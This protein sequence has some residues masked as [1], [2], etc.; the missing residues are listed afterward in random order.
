MTDGRIFRNEKRVRVVRAVKRVYPICILICI[1]I[2]CGFIAR[3][4][5]D[6]E[7]RFPKHIQRP[8]TTIYIDKAMRPHAALTSAGAMNTFDL[9]E[10]T[11]TTLSAYGTCTRVR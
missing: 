10:K 11:A 1:L 7:M 3:S 2:V 9:N 8:V 6:L 5:T 4:Q